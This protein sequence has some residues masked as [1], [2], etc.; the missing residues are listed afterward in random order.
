MLEKFAM[1]YIFVILFEYKYFGGVD[2]AGWDEILKELGEVPSQLDYVRRRYLKRLAEYTGRATIA[3]YSSFLSKPGI[4]NSDVNDVDMTGFM[5]ALKGLDTS[6]GLDLILH[7]PGG[8]PTATEA[9]VDYLKEKFHNDI[10]VIVPQIAMS[11]G[12]MIAC[13]GKEI[14]MGRQSSLGPIDPQF[15]GIPAYNIISEFEEAKQDLLVNPGNAQ[16]WA[17][18]LQQYPAAFMKSAIDAIELSEELIRKWLSDVMLK[19]KPR[20][21]DKAVA[22]LGSHESSKVHGR[23]YRYDE[24]KENGLV[25]SL[26]E[27]DNELQ[28]RILSLHHCYIITFENSPAVKIISNNLGKDF[29]SNIDIKP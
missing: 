13:S 11:A 7:T 2:M 21:I 25:I 3:Y 10:R 20:D 8:D 18:K 14:I 23:H 29:I 22:F 19:D 28:D 12:T 27:D 1:N 6:K 16:Y 26:M 17:I 24:C 9:I 4:V 15:S 5:N